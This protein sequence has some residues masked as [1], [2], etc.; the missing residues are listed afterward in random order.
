VAHVE[1]LLR[2]RLD[3]EEIGD[4]FPD[5]VTLKVNRCNTSALRTEACGHCGE[6]NQNPDEGF[7]PINP[8]CPRVCVWPETRTIQHLYQNGST[9]SLLI[10]PPIPAILMELRLK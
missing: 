3:P 4:A 1:L 9:Y 8:P 2:F 5:Q 6:K 10:W 7:H